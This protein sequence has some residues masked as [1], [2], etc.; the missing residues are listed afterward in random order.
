MEK[1]A[2]TYKAYRFRLYPKPR[3]E[4]YFEEMFRCCRVVYNHFL[5]V[6]MDAYEE[7]KRD[8]SAPIPTQYDMC[9]LLTAFKKEKRDRSGRAFL[10][11]T[12]STALV[13]E[14]GHLED[15]FRR[16]YRRSRDKGSKPGFPH[17]KGRGDKPS[18]T[19]SFKRH[20]LIERNRVRFPKIG[21]VNAK[22]WREVEGRLVSCTISRDASN[23]WWASFLCR[24]VP[25]YPSISPDVQKEAKGMLAR[26]REALDE[27]MRANPS[28]PEAVA[29]RRQARK[30]RRLERQ[31]E[32]RQGSLSAKKASSRGWREAHLALAE[33][34]AR[35]RDKEDTQAKQL[36]ASMRRDA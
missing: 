13:Y 5:R 24:D 26:Q 11:G 14:I 15:A 7:H 27:Y 10:E 1:D 31:L 29:H 8:P 35:E 30:R 32:R 23:R 33:M 34:R 4:A 17:F 20:D 9:R 18:A 25:S 19:I 21:W 6:R 16:F 22:C 2:P 36:A 3:E 12:D 28:S